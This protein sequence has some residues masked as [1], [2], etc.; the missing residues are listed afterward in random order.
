M[1]R[2]RLIAAALLAATIL[3]GCGSASSA[4]P[5]SAAPT[6][7]IA[8]ALIA[9]ARTIGVGPRFRLPATGPVLGACLPRLGTRIEAHIELFASN[10]VVL[11]PSGIGV[12]GPLRRSADRIVGARCYGTLVTLDPTGVVYVRAGE[13]LTLA[14]VFRSWGQPLGRTRL[15]RFPAGEGRRVAVFLDGR[16][17]PTSAPDVALTDHAEI[18]L[19]V[20]PHVPPHSAYTFPPFP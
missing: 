20:G 15:A 19:E 12:R 8:P 17:V 2:R 14:D 18:V 10:H 16:R 1:P 11:V 13:R 3:A 6:G 9:Q 7:T 5:T 4:A